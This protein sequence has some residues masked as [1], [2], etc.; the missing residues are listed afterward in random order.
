M[1]LKDVL[2]D[3]LIEYV[4]FVKGHKNSKGE[5]AEW[6]IVSH[7]RGDFIISSHKSEEEA[8]KK[9]QNMHIFS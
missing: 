5:K 8:K 9:L 3:Y 6:V 1:K 2:E 7:S 4:K